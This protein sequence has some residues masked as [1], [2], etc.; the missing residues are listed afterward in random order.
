ME[1][2]EGVN[3]VQLEVSS[4]G[5]LFPFPLLK[6][7]GEDLAQLAEL[8]HYSSRAILDLIEATGD[9]SRSR[10]GLLLSS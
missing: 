6:L 9:G 5:G 2:V 4:A 8:S 3:N 10:G 7:S 1:D